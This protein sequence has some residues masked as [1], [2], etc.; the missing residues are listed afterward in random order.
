MT[1]TTPTAADRE[2]AEALAVS[3]IDEYAYQPSDNDAYRLGKKLAQAFAD[4]A[5]AVRAECAKSLRD[6]ADNLQR[7]IDN[8][9][10]FLIVECV[11]AV[12]D[13]L[14]ALADLWAAQHHHPR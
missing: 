8:N 13:S 7:C 1:P 2:C 9:N 10:G 4:H 5:A 12:R 6:R 14:R 11:E 3:I